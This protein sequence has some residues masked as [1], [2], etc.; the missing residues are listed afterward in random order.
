MSM[1][2]TWVLLGTLGALGIGFGC[3][4]PKEAARDIGAATPFVS[5]NRSGVVVGV[6]GNTIAVADVENPN[7][8]AAWFNIAPDT[9][10]EKNG[11]RVDLGDISEGTPVRVSFE[12]ATGAEKTFRVEVLTGQEGEQLKQKFQA[13]PDRPDAP[14]QPPESP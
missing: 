14:S 7:E 12:P 6:E 8:P 11:Q 1:R 10:L 3:A 4:G 9:E 13:L 5:Q 2:T